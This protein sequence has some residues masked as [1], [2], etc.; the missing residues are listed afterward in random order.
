MAAAQQGAI[1][2]YLRDVI[3]IGDPVARHQVIQDEGLNLI[4]DFTKFNKEDIETLCSSI[5]KPGG[6]IPNPNTA[7]PGAPAM[8]LNPGFS[9]PAICKKRFVSAA[10]TARIY[11]MIG[12]TIDPANMN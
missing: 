2:T 9:I 11:E 12:R 3:S 4:T 6:T 5:R 7:A 1:R 8:I 10:H